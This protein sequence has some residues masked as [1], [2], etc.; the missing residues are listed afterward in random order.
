MQWFSR[1]TSIAGTE[2]PNWVLVVVAIVV[3]WLIYRLIA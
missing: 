2:I 1:K 3:I